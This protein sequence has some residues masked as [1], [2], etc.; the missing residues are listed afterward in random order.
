VHDTAASRGEYLAL[1][2]QRQSFCGKD[3]VWKACKTSWQKLLYAWW[4]FGQETLRQSWP[5]S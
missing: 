5:V 2:K 1:R 4:Y 3:L